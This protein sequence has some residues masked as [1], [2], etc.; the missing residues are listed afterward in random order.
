[1]AN[2]QLFNGVIL[3]VI[4][5]C[6]DDFWD[7]WCEKNGRNLA[8]NY[9]SHFTH[10]K[11]GKKWQKINKLIWI[12]GDESYSGISWDEHARKNPWRNPGLLHPSSKKTGDF[13]EWG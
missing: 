9:V 7:E 10:Y 2:H 6:L 8:I 1:M 5:R 3:P 11:L 12:N 13:E 4:R